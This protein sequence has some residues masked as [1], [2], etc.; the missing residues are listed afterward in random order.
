[1]FVNVLCALWLTSASHAQGPEH[2]MVAVNIKYPWSRFVCMG[3]KGSEVRNSEL[4]VGPFKFV[5]PNKPVLVIETP[6]EKHLQE[7]GNVCL[8]CKHVCHSRML[9]NE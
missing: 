2:E 8:R 3:L 5:Q 6:P 9:D 4:G 1:M 7:P